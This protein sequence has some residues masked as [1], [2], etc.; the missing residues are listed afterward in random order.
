MCA[1]LKGDTGQENG[2]HGAESRP[3][4]EGQ[5]R[6][7]QAGTGVQGPESLEGPQVASK[8]EF[9]ERCVSRFPG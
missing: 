6:G 1:R 8:P 9:A 2:V 7:P 5:G 3:A 4:Q